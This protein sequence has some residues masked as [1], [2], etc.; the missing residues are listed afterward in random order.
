MQ[1]DSI[2]LLDR[3]SEFRLTLDSKGRTTITMQS[4]G[5]GGRDIATIERM[6]HKDMR[7]LAR[8]LNTLAR[9]AEARARKPDDCAVRNGKG[10]W[11]CPETECPCVLE[12]HGI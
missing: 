4:E 7:K 5:E 12:L 1:M 3:G 11:R 6:S 10:A 2:I 9:E 8:E